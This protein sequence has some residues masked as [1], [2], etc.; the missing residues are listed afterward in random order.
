MAHAPTEHI[1]G[2][3]F[4]TVFRCDWYT[5]MWSNLSVP[6]SKRLEKYN[7]LKTGQCGGE[8]REDTGLY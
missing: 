5:W 4:Y 3:I 6:L 2:D 1:T 8:V 7:P